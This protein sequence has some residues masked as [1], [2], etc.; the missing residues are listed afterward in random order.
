MCTNFL[1]AV[2]MNDNAHE[3]DCTSRAFFGQGSEVTKNT[4]ELS[5]SCLQKEG[6]EGDF[7]NL[8]R[9]EEKIVV[10]REVLSKLS[11]ASFS[12]KSRIS[13]WPGETGMRNGLL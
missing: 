11:P 1:D 5:D 9:T 3:A 10:S 13:P 4:A 7:M 6:K 12:V 8:P 2:A